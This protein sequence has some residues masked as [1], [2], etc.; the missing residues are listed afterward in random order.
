LPALVLATAIAAEAIGARPVV[1]LSLGASSFGATR[2]DLDVLRM[3]ELARDAG[4]ISA[5]PAAVSLG[6]QDDV[7]ADFEPAFRELLLARIRHSGVPLILAPELGESVARRM[8]VYSTASGGVD[9]AAAGRGAIAAFVNVG[10]NAANLGTSPAVLG[11]EPGLNRVL[12]SPAAGRRGVMHEMA[13]RGVPVIHLLHVRGLAL[14]YG[15]PWDP[16]PLP[17]PGTTAIVLD[18]G[19]HE[20]AVGWITVLYLVALV[21]VTASRRIRTR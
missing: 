9:S 20:P 21:I 10:G 19:D 5:P 17:E 7:G 4:V 3:Y 12:S 2:P 11:V 15:L 1:I 8:T 13:A 16:A 6:G 14:R 18:R